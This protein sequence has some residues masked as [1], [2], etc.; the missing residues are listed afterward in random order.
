MLI[1]ELILTYWVDYLLIGMVVVTASIVTHPKAVKAATIGQIL[2]AIPL[3]MCV[4]PV[5]A[6]AR[7]LK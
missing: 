1:L 4:W 7:L 6:T 5:I 2:L 3:A